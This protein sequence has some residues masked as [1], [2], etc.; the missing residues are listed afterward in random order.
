MK[1]AKLIPDRPIDIHKGQCGRIGVLA[2]SRQMMGAAILTARASL[3][4]GSGLVYLMTLEEF[5]PWINTAYPEL[6]VLPLK[7]RGAFLTEASFSNITRY[8]ERYRFDCLAV[9]PGLGREKSTQKMARKVIGYCA[10]KELP[11]VIDADGLMALSVNFFK[12]FSKKVQFVLTPHSKEFDSLF[13]SVPIHNDKN[14]T[15]FC[16]RSL[17]VNS[18]SLTLRAFRKRNVSTTTNVVV[19]NTTIPEK[20]SKAWHAAKHIG[21]VIVFKGHKTVIASPEKVTINSTGNPGMATAG[22][23]DVLTGVIAS[24]IGQGVPVYESAVLGTYIH[25]LAGDIQYREKNIGLIASDIL[26]GI[27]DAI[28]TSK[29]R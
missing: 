20:K 8:I 11:A 18:S 26:E 27:P 17:E 14:N 5:S 4:S 3:R 9:G 22:S 10:Q 15:Y 23:G 13:Q 29:R 1:M 28:R 12:P 16:R 24:W 7:T 21:Q 2:G 6:I 19:D 25:G